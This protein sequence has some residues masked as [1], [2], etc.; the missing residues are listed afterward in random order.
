MMYLLIKQ[1][2]EVHNLKEVIT[3]FCQENTSTIAMVFHVNMLNKT[4]ITPVMPGTG[5]SYSFTLRFLNTRSPLTF[6]ELDICREIGE[7]LVAVSSNLD[8]YYPRELRYRTYPC[9]SLSVFVEKI[10]VNCP[11]LFHV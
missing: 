9:P 7:F 6:S 3:Q 4:P 8:S 11:P 5:K 2:L 1:D 10:K